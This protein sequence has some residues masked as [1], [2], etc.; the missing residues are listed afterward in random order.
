MAKKRSCQKFEVDYDE[1]REVFA[2]GVTNKE[3]A[4]IYGVAERTIRQH[5]SIAGINIGGNK[6]RNEEKHNDAVA[7][8]I[9]YMAEN[10]PDLEYVSG[11]VSQSQ[12]RFSD[13]KNAA[14]NLTGRCER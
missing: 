8:L 5:K 4:E 10:A 14:M 9:S 13:A 11:N 7:R 12:Q 2:S 3:A 1:L 6:E